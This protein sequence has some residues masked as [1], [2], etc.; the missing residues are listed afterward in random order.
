[1]Q[2]V[3]FHPQL[4]LAY[5]E[6]LDGNIDLSISDAK[7]AKEN[8]K[9]LLK[10]FGVKS[11]DLIEAHQIHSTRILPIDVDNSKMWKGQMVTGVD[12]FTTDQSSIAMMIRVAD[13]LP[14]VI[15]DPT[16]HAVGIFHIGWRGAQQGLHL[17]GVKK[18]IQYYQSD[19]KELLVWFGPSAQACCYR[20]AAKPDQAEDPDWQPFIK[21]D[22]NQWVVD[23]PG[24]VSESLK[25][26]GLYKK[27]FHYSDLCTVH[28]EQFFSHQKAKNTKQVGRIAVIAQLQI[29]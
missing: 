10:T 26:F 13:C 6:S 8:R 7:A 22:E 4:K 25:N 16:H 9:Q 23:I 14:L 3:D 29:N 1:M 19:P 5:S 2:L 11:Y 15:L 28:N 18:M 20:S 27:N 17:D 21:P 24:F 12:G